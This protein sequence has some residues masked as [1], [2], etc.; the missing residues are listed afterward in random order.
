MLSH[1]D[2]LKGGEGEELE[3]GMLFS[4]ITQRCQRSPGRDRDA[5]RA[6]GLS[7]LLGN[8]NL[9][10]PT[11]TGASLPRAQ[12]AVSAGCS[13]FPPA[14]ARVQD[15]SDSAEES[16]AL[17]P[18][19]EDGFGEGGN[20]GCRVGTQKERLVSGATYEVLGMASP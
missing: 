18:E 20:W 19:D 6:S 5:G 10:F 2:L 11:L 1:Q 13:P 8:L 9:L 3:S 12:P 17:H 4:T 16:Q 15:S 14:R 7:Q